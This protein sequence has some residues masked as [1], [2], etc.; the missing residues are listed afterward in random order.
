[1]GFG[2]PFL[3]ITHPPDPSHWPC[4]ETDGG[5]PR[6]SSELT[7][8]PGCIKRKDGDHKNLKCPRKGH[9]FLNEISMEGE[10]LKR[11]K[12]RTQIQVE[13]DTAL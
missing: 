1:M 11:Q 13:P 4:K 3:L 12:L 6:N 7:L 8:A 9:Y 10:H 5:R 2:G